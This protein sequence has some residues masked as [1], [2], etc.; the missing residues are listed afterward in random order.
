MREAML[1]AAARLLAD[2]GSAALTARRLAREAGTSTMS[3]YT[4]FGGMP[5][6]FRAVV[7]EGFARLARRFALVPITDDPLAD[8]IA[9]AMAYR[10]NAQDSP[11]LYAVMFGGGSLGGYR[12]QG[13]ELEIGR[14]ET[15]DVLKRATE[16]AME[17]GVLRMGDSG[18]VSAQLWSALHG[19]VAL[20]LAG[21]FE[22]EEG[23]PIERILDPLLLNL[24]AGLGNP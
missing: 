8:L 20:E 23:D 4:H 2:E 21:Y 13:E 11:Q 16:R 22:R 10:A 7:A 17:E 6:L 3:V 12:L 1:R 15:F 14:R 9:L 24:T 18:G 5:E 19:F